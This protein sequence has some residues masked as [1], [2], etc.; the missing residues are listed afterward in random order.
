MKKIL[1][2]II[3]IT[4]LG[5]C[6]K[7]SVNPPQINTPNMYTPTGTAHATLNVNTIDIA[8]YDVKVNLSIGYTNPAET[9]EFADITALAIISPTLIE[10][11]FN[12]YDLSSNGTKTNLI[13]SFIDTA[14]NIVKYTTG[15]NIDNAVAGNTYTK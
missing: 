6:T 3:A 15:I 5:S 11:D 8:A 12:C 7:Q 10:L 9:I 1:V 13:F 2:F 14:T 4:L